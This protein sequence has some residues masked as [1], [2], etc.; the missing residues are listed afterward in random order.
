MTWG[1]RMELGRKTDERELD[2]PS[3]LMD[4]IVL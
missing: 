3:Q 2:S 1:M 4:V